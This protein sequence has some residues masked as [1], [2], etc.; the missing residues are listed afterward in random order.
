M[1]D[2]VF[3]EVWKNKHFGPDVSGTNFTDLDLFVNDLYLK[4]LLF[5]GFRQHGRILSQLNEKIGKV[6][7]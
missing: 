6:L 4:I 3:S 2:L 5:P 1:I 7:D